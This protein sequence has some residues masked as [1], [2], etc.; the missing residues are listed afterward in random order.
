[1]SESTPPSPPP[2]PTPAAT[3]AAKKGLSTLAWVLIVVG[4]LFALTMGACVAC[5]LVVTQAAR[6]LAS[7]FE[8]NPAKAMAE[9]AVRTNPDIELVESDDDAG[10]MTVRNTETG[11]ELTLNFEAITEGRFSITTDKGAVSF[12]T[13]ANGGGITA[14]GVDGSIS[15]IGALGGEDLPEWLDLYPAGTIAPGGFRGATAAGIAGAFQMSTDDACSQ[16]NAFYT[17]ALPAAGFRIVASSASAA[18]AAGASVMVMMQAAMDD[19]ERSVTVT[20][21]DADTGGCAIS[22]QFGGAP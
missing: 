9:L 15:R 22:I 7:D 1:M 4:V 11:D 14:T 2:D 13:D 21:V 10:T 5:G 12:D 20:L 19:P 3:P 6:E 8:T 18:A 16:V 17:E